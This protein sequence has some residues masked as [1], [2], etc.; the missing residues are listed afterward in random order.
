MPS[1]LEVKA[2]ITSIRRASRFALKLGAR[3]QGV[4]AQRD[5]YY[6]SP[7][8]RL[9]VREINGRQCELIYYHRKNFK[10][11]RYSDYRRIPL[12]KPRDMKRLLADLLGVLCVVKKQRRLFLYKNS[13]IHLDT[14]KGL[15]DFLEFE[16][17]V[18]NGKLQARTLMKQLWEAF[19]ICEDAVVAGSYGDFLQQAGARKKF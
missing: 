9:K 10:G 2:R 14:V 16:V 12:E 1:N 6:R 15:G 5:T 18:T 4:L 11:N 7:S 8:G 3:R 17:L 19:E 13:R